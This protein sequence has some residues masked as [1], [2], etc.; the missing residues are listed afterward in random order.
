MST[1]A[2][3]TVNGAYT[4]GVNE[5]IGYAKCSLDSQN[6]TAQRSILLGVGVPEDHIYPSGTTVY[7]VLE[8]AQDRNAGVR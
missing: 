2:I 8:R 6:R 7:R 5:S 3:C 1:S 4:R